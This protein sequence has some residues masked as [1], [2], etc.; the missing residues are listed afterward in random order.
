MVIQNLV[1][2]GPTIKFLGPT[3]RHASGGLRILLNVRQTT[4]EIYLQ[5][6]RPSSRV[7]LRVSVLREEKR[8]L[9]AKGSRAVPIQAIFR[10][11]MARRDDNLIGVCVNVFWTATLHLLGAY[12]SGAGQAAVGITLV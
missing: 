4:Q 9:L 6:Q 7:R 10:G 2:C 12:G 3:G 8:A 5:C 11:F 1:V